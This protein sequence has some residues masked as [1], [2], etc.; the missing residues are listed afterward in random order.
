MNGELGTA[1]I[2]D[3]VLSDHELA[4][5]EHIYVVDKVAMFASY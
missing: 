3:V 5:N 1:Y 4:G 2:L